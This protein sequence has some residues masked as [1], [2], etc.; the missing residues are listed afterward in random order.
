MRLFVAINFNDETR[1]QLLF[2]RDKLRS[3]S[4]YGKF[5]EPENIHLTL[6]FL[7]EC[8]AKQAT[9]AKA[10]MDA[11]S[12]KPF[13]VRIERIGRF[14][15]DGG[16]VWWAGVQESKPLIAMQAELTN[17]PIE[18]GFVLDKRKYS[19]HIT[20]GR[21][22]VTDATPEHVQPFGENINCIELMKSERINGKLTYTAIYTKEAIGFTDKTSGNKQRRA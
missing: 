12:F 3:E 10:A 4:K 2:V 13:P 15:R 5:S 18:A 8:D 16:D 1:A 14:N 17:K 20:F 6:I 21:Q 7:G 11:V 9:S 19:A 22:V